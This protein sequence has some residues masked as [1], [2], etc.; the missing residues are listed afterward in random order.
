MLDLIIKNG[1]DVYG[2]SLEI[3]ISEGEIVEVAD[4]ILQEATDTLV[5]EDGGIISPGWIDSHVHC[6]EKMTLYYD[7]PDEIGIKKGVTT[8]IDAGTSGEKNINDFYDLAKQ[9]KT[10]VFALMNISSPGIVTQDELA[11]LSNINEEKN[12]KRINELSDFIIGIKARMSR[13]VVGDNDVKPLKMAKALQQKVNHLPLMVHIGSAPPELSDILALLEKGD[14]VTHCYNGKLN[15]IL[16]RDGNI[17]EFVWDAFYR[18]INFDIGHGTDS[19]NF[20]VGHTAIEDGLLCKTVST[21]IY[22]RNREDGPV[23]DLA[24]TLEKMLSI[25]IP[26]EK[27]IQMITENP[28]EIFHLEHKGKLAEGMDADITIFHVE[29]GKKCLIDSNGNKVEIDQQIKPDYA[30]VAGKIYPVVA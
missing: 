21:D 19:F 25:G 10:N 14:I 18:G 24:T 16:D 28:A 15:G 29:N 13:T 2:K 8:V 9:A 4:K 3:G 26:L 7:F 27:I 1:T 12:L 30:I 17:K 5:V 11:D 22:H 23:Y 20:E 6:Y